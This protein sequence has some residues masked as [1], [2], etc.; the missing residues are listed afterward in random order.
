MPTHPPSFFRLGLYSLLIAHLVLPYPAIIAC[1]TDP[2]DC[3]DG[4]GS[5]DECDDLGGDEP[6]C[7][8]EEGANPI[9]PSTG[10]VRRSVDDLIGLGANRWARI[11]NSV[12]RAVFRGAPF[13]DG[14]HWRHSHQYDVST[15]LD[16][17]GEMDIQFVYPSGQ[18]VGLTKSS[19]GIYRAPYGKTEIGRL[20]PDNQIEIT[21]EDGVILHFQY[22]LA[23]GFQKW[24]VPTT[25]E[26][27]N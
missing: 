15:D 13:G 18:R 25:A 23:R 27:Q 22:A 4:F 26:G 21:T 24:Y 2:E 3:D 9:N 12:R 11:H 19:D 17:K 7:E 1:D 10:N 6:P 5:D 16:S 20:L 14:G 8:G